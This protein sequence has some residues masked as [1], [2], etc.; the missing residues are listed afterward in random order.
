MILMNKLS[1]FCYALTICHLLNAAYEV[2]ET[3]E[4]E[5]DIQEDELSVNAD[6]QNNF[7]EKVEIYFDMPGD[8]PYH[9]VSICLT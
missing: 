4:G 2:E 9:M 6:F 7:D 8:R 1:V 5:S 3:V